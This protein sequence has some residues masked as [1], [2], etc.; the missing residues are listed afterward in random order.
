MSKFRGP[1]WVA[2]A[3]LVAV[4]VAVPMMASAAPP[5]VF[6]T[7][8]LD[9]LEDVEVCGITVDVVSEGR[10]TDK[11]FLDN[12]GNFVRFQ[13]TA[14]GKNTLTA[15]DGRAVVVRFA[16]LVSEGAPIIDEEA[17]TI[18]FVT[19]VKGLPEKIQTARGPVLLRDAGVIVFANTF[20][21]DTGDLISSETLIT[22][23]PHPDAES[24]FV[25][26]CEIISAELG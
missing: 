24:D 12:D 8:F 22:K 10:F 18:T 26:F 5:D 2:L 4:P 20:D 21:L 13:S 16:N 7:H 1:R 17:G 15:A 3:V 11:V 19:S 14:S 6:H 23:G 25:L 9:V